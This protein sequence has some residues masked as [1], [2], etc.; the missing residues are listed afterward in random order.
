M[1]QY[2]ARL[3]VNQVLL[4]AIIGRGYKRRSSGQVVVCDGVTIRATA[5]TAGDELMLHAELLGI[6]VIADSERKH[7]AETA[8]RYNA[9]AIIMDDGFQHRRLHRDCDIV[10]IDPT[11]LTE[12]TLLPTGRLREP[13]QS[14]LRAHCIVC[15]GGVRIE[16]IPHDILTTNVVLV[17][18]QAILGALY[19]LY[20]YTL[21]ECARMGQSEN[22]QPRSKNLI[23]VSGIAH[24]KRFRQALQGYANQ[25]VRI[26]GE[27]EYVDHARYSTR[28]IEA[29]CAQVRE[30]AADGIVTTE[31]DAVKLRAFL[32]MFESREIP[33]YVAP[34]ELSLVRGK[35]EFHALCLQTIQ[36]FRATHS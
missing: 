24:P 22:N 36:Q 9:S 27:R 7:A 17:E 13:L 31:K 8:L 23:A 6:P 29:I 15:T 35:E 5:D 30:C 3:L 12:P 26:V 18:A 2:V 10:L 32:P 1:A 14:A 11:T 21:H 34:L 16:D 28:M 33:V 4:P 25:G 20:D 19:R